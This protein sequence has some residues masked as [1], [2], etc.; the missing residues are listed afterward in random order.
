MKRLHLLIQN[1]AEFLK[2]ESATRA[3]DFTLPNGEVTEG[4]V[5]NDSAGFMVKIKL[6]YFFFFF[7][8]WK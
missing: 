3:P 6:K 1:W 8:R 5:I 7:F 4:F 2:W